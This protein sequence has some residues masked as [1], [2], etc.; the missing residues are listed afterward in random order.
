MAPEDVYP[1]AEEDCLDAAVFALSEAGVKELGGE[2]RV[3]AGESAGAYLT[4]RTIL[5]LRDQG[6]DVRKRV[7]ALVPN[8]GIFD[9]TYTPSCRAHKRRVIMGGPDTARFI[10]AYLPPEKYTMEKRKAANLSPLYDELH[11]L[12]PALF[13]CGTTDPLLD[14][15]VFMATRYSL[16]NNTT[17]LELTAEGCHGV[18]LFPLGEVAEEGIGKTLDFLTRQLQS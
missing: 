13:L 11:D 10:D 18:T 15:S 5:Q 1:A 2:L 16:A 14:D 7:K 8:C 9:L 4:I 3:I 12:P 6:V 17:E